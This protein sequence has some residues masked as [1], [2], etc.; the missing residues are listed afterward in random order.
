[1]FELWLRLLQRHGCELPA[2]ELARLLKNDVD[3]NT[4]GLIVWLQR[5]KKGHAG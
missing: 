5:Q 2:A 3:L 1:M 4:Q